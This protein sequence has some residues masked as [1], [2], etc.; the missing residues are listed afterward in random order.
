MRQCEFRNNPPR[1]RGQ[2]RRNAFNQCGNLRLKQAIEEEM[3]HHQVVC[4][5]RRYEEAGIGLMQGH[6]L[7]ILQPE[8]LLEKTQH[9]RADIDHIGLQRWI[10]G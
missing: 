10:D 3:G 6:T 8:S 2:S 1:I 7:A 9:G 5:F 4:V